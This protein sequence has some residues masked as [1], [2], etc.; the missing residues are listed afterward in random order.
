MNMYQEALE[1]NDELLEIRKYLHQN[2]ELG[3]ELPITAKF[4]ED[5]L[6]EMGYEPV[7]MAGD[8]IVATVGKEG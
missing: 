1:M 5:K 7:R 8:G 3:L 4:V 6:R 2:P